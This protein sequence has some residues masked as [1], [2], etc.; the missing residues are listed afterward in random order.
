MAASYQTGISTSPTNLLQTIVSWLTGQGWSVDMSQA[1]GLTW[2]VHIHKSGLYVN[3]Q[4]AEDTVIWP[5]QPSG[6]WDAGPGYGI[7]LY[8]GD[9]FDAGLYWS[10]QGGRPVRTDG[11][12]AG[13]GMNLPSGP[14]AAYHFF[15]NGEDHITIVVERSPG[16]F[17]HM[18]WGPSMVKTGFSDDFPY[19]SASSSAYRN[20][21]NDDLHVDRGGINITAYA[22]MSHMDKD[23]V[24]AGSV[25]STAFVR[26]DAIS[27]PD[28][29][30]GNCNNDDAQYAYTGRYLR[31]ALNGNPES[32][33]TCDEDEFPG[34]QYML[35]RVHQT[36]FAG[37]LILPLHCYVLTDPGGR[38]APVGYPPSIFWCEG[39]GHGY[40]AG[41][42]YQI[43]GLDYMLFPHFAVR[44]AT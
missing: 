35:S 8:L 27:F 5:K 38:W 2:R 28:R 44:K 15:D 24:T 1:E 40:A 11:S 20:T 41:A 17:C 6:N 25:H 30:V 22:P 31:C 19:F 23:P 18:C 12:T 4:A 21:F 32:Q 36:A 7:G 9:D 29:W 10:L 3:M 26:V 37:A 14:V 43:G 39:V 16:I 34:Y 13:C 42:I 33:A